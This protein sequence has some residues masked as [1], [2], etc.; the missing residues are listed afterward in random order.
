MRT[1]IVAIS[2]ILAFA[3]LCSE[4]NSNFLGVGSRKIPCE[5]GRLMT[6]NEKCVGG[7]RFMKWKC[8]C[9]WPL[10]CDYS[11]VHKAYVCMGDEEY[12]SDL[13][14]TFKRFVF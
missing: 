5:D 8:E 11:P 14:D 12:D 10:E 6:K 3:L 9:E 7:S 1:T 13:R 2:V 4:A